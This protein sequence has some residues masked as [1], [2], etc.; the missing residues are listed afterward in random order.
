MNPNVSDHKELPYQIF[1]IVFRQALH[2]SS[3]TVD[4]IKSI[5]SRLQVTEASDVNILFYDISKLLL[6]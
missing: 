1:L 4:N 2:M 3:V 6:R 5:L